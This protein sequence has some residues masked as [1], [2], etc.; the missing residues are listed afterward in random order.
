VSYR[1]GIGSGIR[2]GL[3]IGIA[4]GVALWSL[5]FGA[6]VGFWA[7]TRRLRPIVL[8]GDPMCGCRGGDG[9]ALSGAE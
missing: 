5:V 8:L 4:I 1:R 9:R 2:F 6:L 7:A 3:G